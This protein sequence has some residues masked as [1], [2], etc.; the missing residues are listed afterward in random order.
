MKKI[1][2][3]LLCCGIG[4]FAYSQNTGTSINDDGSNPDPSAVLQVQSTA[5]G[6]L[7]P[8]MTKAQRNAISNPAD[9]LMI[10]QTDGLRG[11]YYY[12]NLNN[13]GGPEWIRAA[14]KWSNHNDSI[15]TIFF[16]PPNVG[17]PKVGIGMS[18]PRTYLDVAGSI[19]VGANEFAPT[20]NN[21]PINGMLVG[22][23]VGIN[24]DQANQNLL[25]IGG[26]N[27]SAIGT[28]LGAYFSARN[29]GTGQYETYL[30]PRGNPSNTLSM[31][32]SNGGMNIMD[33]NS[34]S[35]LYI[36]PAGNIGIGM[37][38]LPSTPPKFSVQ[39]NGFYTGN[40]SIG[41]NNGNTNASNRLSISGGNSDFSG[42]VSIGQFTTNSSN[43]FTVNGGNSDFS[44]NVAIGQPTTNSSNK[45]TVTGGNSDFTGNVGI[46]Y[47]QTNFSNRL[48][49]NGN[50]DIAGNLGIG[51]PNPAFKLHVNGTGKL[52]GNMVFDANVSTGG[53]LSVGQPNTNNSN[54]FSV[55]GVSNFSSNVS[56]G[57][58]SANNRLTVSGKSDFSDNV[59]IGATST[60]NNNKFTV[61]GNTDFSGNVG[62]NVSNPINKL[63]VNV[64]AS[65]L[66]IVSSNTATDPN[67]INSYPLAITGSKQGIYIK[68]NSTNAVNSNNFIN[69][70]D[71]T[72]TVGCIE[73]E[74]AGEAVT[75]PAWLTRELFSAMFL[76][77]DI[78]ATIADFVG[79]D[80]ADRGTFP[81]VIQAA[82]DA[83]WFAW[84]YAEK[85]VKAG[86]SYT[87]GSADYAEWIERKDINEVIKPGDIIGVK[88]GKISKNTLN[89]D[90]LMVISTAPAVLGNM[91]SQGLEKNYEKV[92][93]MGQVQIKV[94]GK[95]SA[96]DFIVCSGYNDGIGLG[97]HPDQ[98]KASDYANVVGLA[99]TDNAIGSGRVN[100]L[101]NVSH[102]KFNT[103][104]SQQKS[105]IASLNNKVESMEAFLKSKFPD[106][107]GDSET[108]EQLADVSNLSHLGKS[109]F[110][111]DGSIDF[112][113]KAVKEVALIDETGKIKFDLL[114]KKLNDMPGA[115]NTIQQ[116]MRSRMKSAGIDVN[117]PEI[118]KALAPDFLLKK[119]DEMS[120]YFEN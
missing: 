2:L 109:A 116:I 4:Q 48:S 61:I 24:T 6:M 37:V 67:D 118:Q 115:I 103:V 91:P 20:S 32:Y 53:N 45:F 119:I 72:K 35:S 110:N 57:Q 101:V 106:Y 42:N 93:F 44:G 100:A 76:G 16:N 59:S 88:N 78:G 108:D 34:N 33:G 22:G 3:F 21:P 81:D 97:I 60:N 18:S 49:V 104:I 38:V 87:T 19:R 92:A 47:S 68:V 10:Y 113:N 84:D 99:W 40:L 64:G 75:D 112:N 95:V 56:I 83:L 102:A 65:R 94:E 111:K 58:A 7:I 70:S 31:Y 14:S 107:D 90:H 9:G 105:E 80:D 120:K 36:S 43:K 62:I 69:F 114:K 39:G 79:L 50:S 98:M 63:D 51:V 26:A 66:N 25:T 73:G 28:G 77:A 86:V 13:G 41:T 74:T 82:G 23:P 85:V 17:F 30:V 71:N 117:N 54:R 5:K 27:V 11:F 52:T 29:A 46:G 96:G 8:R 1:I 15:G 89:A 55:N 12:D